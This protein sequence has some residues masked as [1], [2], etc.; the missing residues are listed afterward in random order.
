MSLAAM[1]KKLQI[2]FRFNSTPMVIPQNFDFFIKTNILDF[3]L[4]RFPEGIDMT[5]F[6]CRNS[7]LKIFIVYL[8]L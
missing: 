1:S 6:N 3:D 5:T 7:K 4:H 2:I 8:I